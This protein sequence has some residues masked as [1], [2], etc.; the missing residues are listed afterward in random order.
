MRLHPRSGLFLPIAMLAT[1]A[2][3]APPEGGVE[4][5]QLWDSEAELGI[6]TA[7]GNSETSTYTGSVSG[8]R[9]SEKT[10]LH[11][12][13][14]GRYSKE[15][16]NPTTQRLHGLSQFDYKFRPEIYTFGLLDAL[17][18]RFGGYEL[19]LIESLGVGRMFFVD[20]DDL[21]W[22]ADIGPALRQQW[23]VDETY[24]NSF[25]VRARTLVKWEFAENSTL[26]EQ[27]TWTQSVK[28][29]DE[30]LF[31]SETGVSFRINSNLAFKTSVLVQHDSQPPEGTERTDVFTTT[32]LLYSF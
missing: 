2:N 25:N 10:K 14:D 12:Q 9:E 8:D 24:E 1:T 22:Q 11:L 17:H 21:D 4:S 6:S 3:A 18:D 5:E 31:S 32:S 29:E 28:D 27:F 26:Q 15:Q 16:G 20:R 19:Q 23:L 7:S 13:A 30:Y